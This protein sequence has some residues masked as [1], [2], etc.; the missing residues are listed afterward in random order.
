M[1]RRGFSFPSRAF[2]VAGN[3]ERQPFLLFSFRPFSNPSSQTSSPFTTH[4]HDCII[5]QT[6]THYIS[7]TRSVNSHFPVYDSRVSC[8]VPHLRL[9]ASLAT[10]NATPLFSSSQPPSFNHLPTTSPNDL[11]PTSSPTANMSPLERFSKWIQLK[12]YQFEVTYSVYMLTPME[13]FFVCKSIVLSSLR[14]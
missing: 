11:S 14:S 8:L 9:S 7:T 13:K 6:R 10:I 1:G 5:A 4:D 12:I 3:P 2:P